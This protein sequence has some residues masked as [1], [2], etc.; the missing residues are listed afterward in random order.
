MQ[1]IYRVLKPGGQFVLVAEV[2]KIQYHMKEYND[3]KKTH[4]LFEE[5]GFN[6]IDLQS[7][8]KYICIIGYN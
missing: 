7:N 1:E 8:K 6:N 5:S 3:I 2:Y 4:A